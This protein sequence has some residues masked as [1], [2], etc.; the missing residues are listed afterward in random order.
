[1]AATTTDNVANLLDR[2]VPAFSTAE[3]HAMAKQHFNLEGEFKALASERDLGFRVTTPAGEQYVFKISNAKD[4]P[5][6][7]DFQTQALLHL[8]TQAP[9]LPTPRIIPTQ[10]GEDCA[11]VDGK[12]GDKHIVRV[13]SFLQGEIVGANPQYNTPTLRRNFGQTM[14]RLDTALRGFF[15]PHARNPHPWDMMNF[16]IY[17][18]HTQHVPDAETRA[19]VEQVFDHANSLLPKLKGLRHQVIH[20]DAH[21]HNLLVAADDPERITGLID[22]GDMLHG[23]LLMDLVVSCDFMMHRVDDPVGD[24]CDIIA[25]YDSELELE[26]QEIDLL[27]DMILVRNCITITICAWR[28]AMSPNEPPYID[29]IEAYW[30]LLE[31]LTTLGREAVTN[32]FRAACRFPVY[33]PVIGEQRSL[34][35]E[36]EAELAQRRKRLLGEKTWHFY[37]DP[38][39]VERARGSWLYGADGKGYLDLYNNVPQVGHCHPHVARA[40]ARQMKVLNTN[41]RYLYQAVL[42][43]AER[44]IAL[45]PDHLDACVFVNSGSEANDVAVQMCKLITGNQGGIMVEDAYHGIT[46][47][48]QDLSPISRP[49][50]PEHIAT[51]GVP[52]PYRGPHADQDNMA[53]RYAED[54]DRAISQLDERGIKPAYFMIDSAYCSSGVVDVPEGYLALIEQKVRAAGGLMIAD[55]VQSG[56]GRLG[57]M[58][59]HEARGLNADI[60]T[61]GK[62][63]GNGHPLGVII[64]RRDILDRFI[65]ETDLFSTFGGNAV[66]CAAGMAVLDVIEQENLIDNANRTGDYLRA[67]M[68]QLG[69]TQPLIG[70]VR[71]Q[72]MLAA[73]EFVT[74]RETKAPAKE[75]TARLIEMMREEGVLIGRSGPL[76]NSLKLRPNLAFKAEEVDIFIA[77]LDKCLSRLT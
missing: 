47:I 2:N 10:G 46:D 40:V 21:S 27:Y 1:M 18:P 74:D 66:S 4:D 75:Q 42:D 48:T 62:P 23:P 16:M 26:E 53:A 22:F 19:R 25:G 20:Q 77:A 65:E 50:L 29:N 6:L 71:G 41:T 56:F 36:H 31:K 38:L 3:V 8:T 39:H 9:E 13:L 60:M 37:N 35:A 30:A 67:Q 5:G 57:Q 7:I 51:L 58:W 17:R 12:N 54:A 14:A 32:R 34:N 11:V 59:G 52:C 70:D 44:L 15:H 72:G 68:R 28:A 33:S 76:R 69:N 49:T 63:V 64:T 24:M 45:T 73:V 43:Y 61:L 55:E